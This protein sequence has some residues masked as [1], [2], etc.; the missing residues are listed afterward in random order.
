MD[1]GEHTARSNGY[2]AEELVQLLVIANCKLKVSGNNSALLVVA[3]GVACELE[4]F[5]SEILKY[6]GE[7]N[8]GS[9]ANTLGVAALLQ[10]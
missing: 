8:W 4:N 3:G 2:A 10:V 7:V 1:V 9:A 6:S 5:G